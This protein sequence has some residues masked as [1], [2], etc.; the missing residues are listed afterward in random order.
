VYGIQLSLGGIIEGEKRKGMFGGATPPKLSSKNNKR[1]VNELGSCRAKIQAK[2]KAKERKRINKNHST[3]K[4]KSPVP[5]RGR[6]SQ[7]Y[8]SLLCR[9][10]KEGS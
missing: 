6:E 8:G 7:A 3:R 2:K 5:V 10:L 9:R 4:L 1:G